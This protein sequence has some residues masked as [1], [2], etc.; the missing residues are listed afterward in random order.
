MKTPKNIVS[1]K[2]FN[3][4]GRKA[5]EEGKLDQAE[6]LLRTALEKAESVGR[7]HWRLATSL[8]NL[9]EVCRRQKRIAEA[10]KF[11]LRA[12]KLDE[13]L[14]RDD[15]RNRKASIGKDSGLSLY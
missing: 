12:I 4:F 14:L 5:L 9:G 1:W 3:F 6:K 7:S 15:Q 11:F 10:E 8:N 13:T 2:S